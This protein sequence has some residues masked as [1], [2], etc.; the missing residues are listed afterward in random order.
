MVNATQY[1]GITVDSKAVTTPVGVVSQT[2]WDPADEMTEVLTCVV[3]NNQA[4]HIFKAGAKSIAVNVRYSY[5]VS[6]V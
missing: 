1:D 2:N 3:K 4:Y 5:E 6:E